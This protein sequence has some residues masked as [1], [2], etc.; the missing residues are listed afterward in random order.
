MKIFYL[1]IPKTAGSWIEHNSFRNG[2]YNILPQGGHRTPNNKVS[3]SK[4]FCPPDNLKEGRDDKWFY[5]PFQDVSNYRCFS[6]LRNPFDWLVSY[7]NHKKSNH[8][9][10]A[11]CNVIHGFKSFEEFVKFYCNED[12]IWHVPTVHKFMTAMVFDHEGVCKSEAFIYYET[13]NESL[14]QLFPSIKPTGF[15]KSKNNYKSFYTQDMIDMVS[16]KFKI[17][18]KM[19]GYDFNG[20]TNEKLVFYPDQNHR[21][22]L[23]ENK[24]WRIDE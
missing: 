19:Y 16:E 22:D 21:Y 5:I 6:V 23:I 10:W 1:H 8:S 24:H 12:N 9:G 18:L 13:M 15:K 20:R 11:N 3:Q 4:Y 7:Y 2:H 17:E 14:K